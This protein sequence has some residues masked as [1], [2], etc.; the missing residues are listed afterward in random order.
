MTLKNK[1]LTYLG[2]CPSRESAQ[3]FRVRYNTITLKQ[4]EYRKAI[5]VGIASGVVG[6]T[7]IL[8]LNQGKYPWDPWR[9]IITNSIFFV[10]A[11]LISANLRMRREAKKE[12]AVQRRE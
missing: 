3:D 12:E 7:I 9:F 1:L 8:Y 10:I 6:A 4:K 5:I 11:H 2:F